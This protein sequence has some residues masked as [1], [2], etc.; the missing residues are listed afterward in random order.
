[1]FIKHFMAFNIN[2][3][4]KMHKIGY[5]HNTRLNSPNQPSLKKNPTAILF[6]V[7]RARFKCLF[8]IVNKTCHI[9]RRRS[10]SLM[11]TVNSIIAHVTNY[12]ICSYPTRKLLNFASIFTDRSSLCQGNHFDGCTFIKLQQIQ[13]RCCITVTVIQVFAVYTDILLRNSDAKIIW[14][15]PESDWCYE[16]PGGR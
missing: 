3:T 8:F 11:K 4:R 9:S 15:E 1:M 2:I 12:V 6:T 13:I 14:P 10:E 16:H 5:H 7:A